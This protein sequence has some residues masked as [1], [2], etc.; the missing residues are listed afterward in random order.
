MGFRCR[1][2]GHR[3]H[4]HVCISC[5]CI[6]SVASDELCLIR[7]YMGFW[8]RVSGPKIHENVCVS[9][10][11]V[12]SVGWDALSLV[13]IWIFRLGFRV[14]KYMNT[15]AYHMNASR[16]WFRMR[17]VSYEWVMSRI[18]E[19]RSACVCVCVRERES[20]ITHTHKTSR[21]LRVDALGF[22]VEAHTHRPP[23]VGVVFTVYG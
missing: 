9:Y 20:K 23:H 13:W 8:L 3:I 22:K 5:E 6:M 18:N 4:E 12:M 16:K 1:V 21:T 7:I 17:H 15:Y 2:S 19:P 14:P 11:C 10:D